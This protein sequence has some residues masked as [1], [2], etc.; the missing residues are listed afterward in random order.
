MGTFGQLHPQL[1]Q[2]RGL[3]DEVYGF[4][5]DMPVLIQHLDQDDALV[6]LFQ[7]FSTYPA[8]DR[9]IAFF[10]SDQTSVAELERAIRKEGKDLLESVELFDEYRGENV[11]SGQRSL[12]FRLVYRAGD[13]T[14]TDE[15]I[16]PIHQQVREVLVDK[17][18]VELRS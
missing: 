12:A 9:D 8:S 6:P 15:D 17:F 16:D 13:R 7:P 3:P 10:V 1:R 2:E 5:L 18:R 11:P 14:L 4:E